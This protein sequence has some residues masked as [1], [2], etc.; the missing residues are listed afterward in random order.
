M[1]GVL[2]PHCYPLLMHFITTSNSC[3]HLQ[4]IRAY[5]RYAGSSSPVD[6]WRRF[7]GGKGEC[8][9]KGVESTECPHP[10]FTQLQPAH[11]TPCLKSACCDEVHPAK[12]TPPLL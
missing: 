6:K 1:Q 7:A 11:T 4:S 2:C 8:T 10:P 9:V 5:N 12:L 3:S